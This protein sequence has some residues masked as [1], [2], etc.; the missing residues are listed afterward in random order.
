MPAAEFS[1]QISLAGTEASGTGNMKLMLNGAVTIGTR[2]GA[3]VEIREAV[4]EENILIF[5]LTTSGRRTL[6]KRDGY[7]PQKYYNNNADLRPLPSITSTKAST[8]SRSAKS[9]APFFIH[10]PY[11]VLADYEDYRRTQAAA[12]GA[13]ARRAA[14]SAD[15]A[16]KHCRERVVSRRPRAKGTMQIRFGTRNP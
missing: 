11:M 7:V 3:N 1:E 13:V 4:G 2:D 6:L 10:D 12:E 14:F 5:G 8:A 9:A 16:D 15:V